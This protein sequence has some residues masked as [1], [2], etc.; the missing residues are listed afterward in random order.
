[1]VEVSDA[2]VRFDRYGKAP[3]Y[4]IAGIPEYWLVD[5]NAEVVEVYRHPS[6]DGYRSVETFNREGFLS[7]LALPGLVISG[8]DV[9]G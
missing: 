6:P 1:V 7:P 8:R 9:L 5:L 4:S 3:L 2:S